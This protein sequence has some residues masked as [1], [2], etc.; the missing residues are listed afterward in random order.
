M[1]NEKCPCCPNHCGKNSLKCEKGK[2]Y[3][4]QDVPNSQKSNDEFHHNHHRNHH[5]EHKHFS[6]ENKN[7]Q[8]L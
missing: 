2:A 4:S 7:A 5:K 8:V 3:F 6:N 1:N